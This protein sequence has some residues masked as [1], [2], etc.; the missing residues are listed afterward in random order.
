MSKPSP[1]AQVDPV[2]SFSEIARL[3]GV[4]PERVRQIEA[5]ALRKLRTEFTKRGLSAGDFIETWRH[6]HPER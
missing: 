6:A 2:M 4:T 5:S 3:M 1:I